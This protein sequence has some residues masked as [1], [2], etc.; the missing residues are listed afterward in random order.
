MKQVRWQIP[1]VSVGGTHYRIDIYDEQDG[2][3]SG[4]QTLIGGETPFVTDEDDSDDFFYP[5]RSQSGTIEVCTLMPDGNY[6]TLDD[7]LPANNIARPVRLIN[8]DNSDAIE[9]QGFLSCEAY[10]QDYTDIPQILQLPI[11]SVLEAMDS[12]YLSSA[13][14]LRPINEVVYTALNN[15]EIES[16]MYYTNTMWR[17]I[18]YSASAFRIFQQRMNDCSL[19][20]EDEIQTSDSLTYIMQGISCKEA[21]ARIC[22]FMGWT[23]RE[24]GQDIYLEAIGETIGMYRD[25]LGNFRYA[26]HTN[27]TFVDLSTVD[28]SNQTWMGINHK[29]SITQGAH[30]VEVVAKLD[31]SD[32]EV[33]LPDF[34]SNN[35]TTAFGMATKGPYNGVL[36]K[37]YPWLIAEQN[38]AYYNICTFHYGVGT[39]T[40]VSYQSYNWITNG[41]TES[42]RADF[43][44]HSYL[45]AGG[46]SGTT[47]YA[48]AAFVQFSITHQPWGGY[49]ENKQGLY[50]T[51]LPNLYAAHPQPIFTLRS[52][53]KFLAPT[54][55]TARLKVTAKCYFI[56]YDRTNNQAIITEDISDEFLNIKYARYAPIVRWGMRYYSN[57]WHD[58]E[59]YSSASGAGGEFVKGGFEI[60][61]H[62][63]GGETGDIEIGLP[64]G[65]SIDNRDTNTLYEV[66]FTELSVRMEYSDD[67]TWR[68]SDENRYITLLN[69]NFR[70]EINVDVDLASDNFNH[71][72]ISHLYNPTFG[73]LK[74][75]DYTVSGGTEA[76]RPEVDL[77]NRLAAYYGAAR[78]RLELIVEHPTVAPMPLLRLNGISPDTRKYLP[79]AES[80]D[81]QQDTSTLKCFETPAES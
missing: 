11:I 48:G 25:T 71:P 51:L 43:L 46:I 19:Y 58:W 37:L 81:W 33:E 2:S 62:L 40:A 75:L 32:A 34:P 60:S 68:D 45:K 44:N 3:W 54:G 57:G 65:Y 77:L 47:K 23:A 26:F 56:G 74:T 18:Y 31:R 16:G 49:R 64:P 73:L 76:R 28:L 38:D 22:A 36:T 78:Q 29:K 66:I 53:K 67:I 70:D 20:E 17:H 52:V 21:I 5:V 35:P 59:G 79:L 12:V 13:G 50:C 41:Y 14:G 6:I 8:R 27:A 61:I 4:V 24:S 1:F 9:W 39:V 55:V 63:N 30:R 42:T 10:D 72:S 69:T 15:I 80:R 7:L